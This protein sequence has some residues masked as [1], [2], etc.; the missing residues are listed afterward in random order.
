MERLALYAGACLVLMGVGATS[1]H[2]APLVGPQA[3][4]VAKDKKI[5]DLSDKLKASERAVQARDDA[6]RARDAQTAE[7]AATAATEAAQMAAMMKT[8][9]KGAFDAGYA[10]RR[11]SGP[12]AAGVRDLRSIQ[13]EGAFTPSG[14]VP[15][16]PEG[17]R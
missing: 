13:A 14:D 6:I 5:A 9:C 12:A 8:T 16:K 10:S 2:W 4:F 1:W 7:N 11:C 15:A 3:Q 17:P